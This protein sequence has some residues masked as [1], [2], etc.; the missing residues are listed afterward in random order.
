MSHSSGN[1]PASWPCGRAN[2]AVHRTSSIV[3]SSMA[4]VIAT[5]FRRFPA[6]SFFLLSSNR[7]LPPTRTWLGP[8]LLAG[9]ADPL[10]EAAGS[11]PSL[12]PQ[13]PRSWSLRPRPPRLVQPLGGV[14]G[15]RTG[16]ICQRGRYLH[17]TTLDAAL[18]RPLPPSIPSPHPYA[19]EGGLTWG[20]PTPC[21]PRN[22]CSRPSSL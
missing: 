9:A 7:I 19:A 22:L 11:V 10:A 14:R 18:A 12:L 2:Q 6:T 1:Q 8:L 17:P 5:S 3:S 13:I 15:P 21:Q 16:E 20:A 4:C